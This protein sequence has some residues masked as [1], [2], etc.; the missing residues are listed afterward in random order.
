MGANTRQVTD[1]RNLVEPRC[2]TK[3]GYRAFRSAALR[4]YNNKLPNTIYMIDNLLSFKKKLK[5]HLFSEAYDMDYSSIKKTFK[6]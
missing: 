4:L 2:C 6:V 3:I 1:G 5:A